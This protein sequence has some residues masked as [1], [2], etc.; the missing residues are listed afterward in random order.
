LKKFRLACALKP[1][2]RPHA[3]LCSLAGALFASGRARA[4]G[5]F[6]PSRIS[7]NPSLKVPLSPA[8]LRGFFVRAARNQQCGLGVES[9][10]LSSGR[11]AGPCYGTSWPTK[12]R[13]LAGLLFGAGRLFVQTAFNI[14]M[15]PSPEGGKHTWRKHDDQVNCC[16]RLSRGRRNFGAR[17]NSGADSSAGRHALASSLGVRPV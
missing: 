6:R 5:G 11:L 2:L 16:R 15:L 13:Y 17:D 12:P 1:L 14:A 4:G 10:G 9:A 8:P 7:A 3:S